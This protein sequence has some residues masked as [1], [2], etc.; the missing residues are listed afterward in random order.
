MTV[1][2]I[3]TIIIPTLQV[4][5]T[6]MKKKHNLP[7]AVPLIAEPRFKSRQASPRTCLLMY[8]MP[9]LEILEVF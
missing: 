5:K 4:K 6:E 7:K 3:G 1:W 2:S 9:P 8:M